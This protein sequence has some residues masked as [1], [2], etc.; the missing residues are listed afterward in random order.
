[1]ESDLQAKKI[2]ASYWMQIHGACNL[3]LFGQQVEMAL[4]TIGRINQLMQC[5]DSE[6]NK[7]W[8]RDEA[9]GMHR[10]MVDLRPFM[11][12][13]ARNGHVPFHGLIDTLRGFGFRF[14]DGNKED[15]EQG[16]EWGSVFEARIKIAI[17][18][19]KAKD[20]DLPD[21]LICNFADLAQL[22]SPGHF[23]EWVSEW[24]E[25]SAPSPPEHANGHNE[26]PLA[27]TGQAA[28]SGDP[29]SFLPENEPYRT[30]VIAICQG[31][32]WA[33]E[34]QNAHEENLLHGKTLSANRVAA[35]ILKYP[36]QWWDEEKMGKDD[37]P[38]HKKVAEWVSKWLQ[39]GRP[40]PDT[41]KLPYSMAK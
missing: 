36:G 16:R 38:A 2:G 19:G 9:Y 8:C 12:L 21:S 29:W 11:L 37:P 31:A 22:A 27:G 35:V 30:H 15:H 4:A 34:N 28:A 39:A 3:F 23:L 40:D 7:P 10:R 26:P 25:E 20:S 41:I 24:R 13:A 1:M 32:K 17:D 18:D 5:V 14:G 33:T 6:P